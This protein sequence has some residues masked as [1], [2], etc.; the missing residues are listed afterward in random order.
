MTQN[1]TSEKRTGRVNLVLPP[2][3]KENLTKIAN[4]KGVSLN[5]LANTIFQELVNKY[6]PKI[7][8]Y[9]ACI[10]KINSEPRKLFFSRFTIKDRL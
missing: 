5:E 10:A 1:N 7:R 2:T 8:E 6:E 3:L 9:D 4:I